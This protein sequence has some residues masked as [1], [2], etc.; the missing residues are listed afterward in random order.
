[1]KRSYSRCRKQKVLLFLVYH[2]IPI[3]M[4]GFDSYDKQTRVLENTPKVLEKNYRR[5]T[6][7]EAQNYFLIGDDSIIRRWWETKEKILVGDI[8]MAYPPKWPV[9]EK[10]LVQQFT[11][12]RNN[13]KIITIHWFRRILRQIWN[14]LYFLS[15]INVFVFFKWLVLAIP[16]PP[17]YYAPK[18]HQS[19]H[20]PARRSGECNQFIHIAQLKAW[21]PGGYVC[22]HGA[23]VLTPELGHW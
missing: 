17:R 11:A 5:P 19:G 18:N 9:L 12:A 6:I 4:N 15:L 2:R 8:F 23:S 13:N 16:P 22:E 3:L 21:P 20:P 10:E 7:A 1:V 14:R